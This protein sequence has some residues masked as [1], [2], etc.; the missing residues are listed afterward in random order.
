MDIRA[1]RVRQ[2]L[3]R[4]G[5][6]VDVNI[7]HRHSGEGFNASFQVVGQT[8]SAFLL[9]LGETAILRGLTLD[10]SHCFYVGRLLLI[11]KIY[12]IRRWRN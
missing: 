11:N 9:S 12:P 7:I 6:V 2:C 5:L 10:R 8:S 1:L 3:Q 4:G